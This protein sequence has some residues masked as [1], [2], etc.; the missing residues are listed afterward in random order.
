MDLAIGVD[1]GYSP[2]R[3]SAAAAIIDQRTKTIA[4]GGEISF[5]R[6]PDVLGFILAELVRIAPRGVTTVIDGPFAGALAPSKARRIERLFMSGPF[7]AA[8]PGGGPRLRLMPAPTAAGSKFLAQ[9]RTVVDAIV[10]VEQL[11]A[12][13]SGSALLGSVVEIFPTVFMGALLPPHPY[14]GARRVHTDK[15]WRRLTG[16]LEL[17]RVLEASSALAPYMALIAEV[18]GGRPNELHDRR[19]AAIC[20]IAADWFAASPPGDGGPSATM[21]IGHPAEGGFLLPP[22]ALCNPTFL[23]MLDAHWLQR[24]AGDLFWV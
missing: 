15:L 19:A 9:T 3:P 16:S 1:I 13:V 11:E 4:E 22:R 20:S 10:S 8:P 2:K 7:A 6:L 5:G 23:A 12:R 24:Q 21:Y 17:D 14:T 18:D